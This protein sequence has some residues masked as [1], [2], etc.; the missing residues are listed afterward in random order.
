MTGLP[1]SPT[2]PP[3]SFASD[4]R[5]LLETQPSQASEIPEWNARVLEIE[6]RLRTATEGPQ[7]SVPS[8]VWRWINDVDMRLKDEDYNS[9]L[10]TRFLGDIEQLERMG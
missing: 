3:K 8:Y 7:Y 4:L 9:W 10:T 5:R 2:Y 6:N 1:M